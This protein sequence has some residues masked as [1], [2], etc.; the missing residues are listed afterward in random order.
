MKYLIYLITISLFL[1][2][3]GSAQN[4]KKE[5]AQKEDL[6]QTTEQQDE[7]ETRTGWMEVKTPTNDSTEK[8]IDKEKL[9]KLAVKDKKTPEQI[10]RDN[11]LKEARS[12]FRKGIEFYN[13]KQIDDAIIMFKETLMYDPENALA[14]YNLGKIYY[15]T[16]QKDMS[17]AYYQDALNF[18]PQDSNSIVAIGL[19]YFERSEFDSA[20]D[21]FNQAI[22]LAP[23]YGLAYYNRGTL[24][25]QQK[26]Y[27]QSLDDL[28]KAAKYSPENSKVFMNRGMAYFFMKNLPAACEDWNKAAG[29]GN[30]EAIKAVS[31]YCKT[32]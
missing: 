30:S 17:L 15:E 4:T 27:Q 14:F 7:P 19:I 26:Y 32:K 22:E 12:S 10:K 23:A 28:N 21:Y 1:A 11:D 13:K 29:M 2:S 16:G 3:C 5:K 6:S 18:N 20:M 8:N 9:S 25:G 24:L 31:I